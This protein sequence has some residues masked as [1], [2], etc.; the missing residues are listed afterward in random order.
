MGSCGTTRLCV[1]GG[2]TTAADPS[3]NER[4]GSLAPL[5]LLAVADE[6]DDDDDDDKD[7]R[8]RCCWSCTSDAPK[9][10]NGLELPPPWPDDEPPRDNDDEDD[11]GDDDVAAVAAAAGGAE[12]PKG[13]NMLNGLPLADM[14]IIDARDASVRRRDVNWGS[15]PAAL[16][17]RT[18]QP[19]QFLGR[20]FSPIFLSNTK[21][22][23]PHPL[24]LLW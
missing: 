15:S 14:I 13:S 19:R 9:T 1:G 2:T 21:R 16:C 20:G 8:G 24:E 17:C 11:D 23:V 4:E 3:W 5:P 22:S 7:G 12:E 6:N 18:Q 10:S